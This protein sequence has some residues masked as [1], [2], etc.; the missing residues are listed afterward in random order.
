M[1]GD[2][3][4]AATAE[5]IGLVNHLAP[6][7]E[8]LPRALEMAGRLAQGPRLA[9]AF[10]KQAINAA[11]EADVAMAMALSVA[12]EARTFTQPDVVEGIAAFREKRAARWP[13]TEPES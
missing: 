11:I 6:K 13:S 3:L 7:D 4:D 9:I 8:V 1:T 12:Q 10:T 5:R 2:L